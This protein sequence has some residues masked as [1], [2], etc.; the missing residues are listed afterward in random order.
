M[1]KKRYN[2]FKEVK[3]N[4]GMTTTEAIGWGT[5]GKI[6]GAINNPVAD[7]A[8]GIGSSLAGVPSLVQA[9]G[10]VLKGLGMF[11]SYGKRKHK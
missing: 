1:N 2:P 6:T 11:D 10:S 3:M 7:K 4:I 5:S 8:F 9:S